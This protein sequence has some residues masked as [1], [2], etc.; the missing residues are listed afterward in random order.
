MLRDILPTKLVDVFETK[1]NYSTL[2][3]IRFRMDK[4]VVVFMNG[5]AFFLGENG[6]TNNVNHAVVASKTMIEDIVYRAS[7][8]SIYSVNEQIKL[9][10][11]MAANGVRVGLAGTIV[12]ENNQIKTIRDF[13]S[14]NIR[15]PH[16]I[17]GCCLDAFS[18]IVTSGG[19]KNTLVLSPPGCGKTTFLRDFLKQ[20]SS[21]N[22]CLNV[23]VV[24]E[25]GEIACVS[26]KG[27]AFDIGNFSD[28][29][30]FSSKT[31]AIEHGVRVLSPNLIVTDELAGGDDV[32]AV[33]RAINSGVGVV[34]SIH[35]DSIEMLKRK[36]D[37]APLV[38]NKYFE[39]YVVL[40]NRKGPGTC[41]G[42]Y[43]E[44]FRRI[45]HFS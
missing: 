7:E 19:I 9:G 45:S 30:S 26:D 18:D 17:R 16:E 8:C 32:E 2:N 4:P 27:Q 39:R 36:K 20:L 28:I 1:I 12:M 34:S 5:Q 15:I 44:N 38:E 13:S 40:S 25:R 23:L 31:R 10:F 11:V 42:I 14:L 37:F 6:L 22:Y 3:E 43:D 41:E 21:K 35:A 33:I 29:I 24:D